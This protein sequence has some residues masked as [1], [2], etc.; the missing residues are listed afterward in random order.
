MAGLPSWVPRPCPQRG[1]MEQVSPGSQAPAPR[2][3]PPSCSAASCHEVIAT[4]PSLH[5]PTSNLPVL[6]S[7]LAKRLEKPLTLPDPEFMDW[8]GPVGHRLAVWARGLQNEGRPPQAFIPRLK[9]TPAPK[10]LL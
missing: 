6:T 7:H 9:P 8:S 10:T 1:P 3:L 5:P 2:P 4:F